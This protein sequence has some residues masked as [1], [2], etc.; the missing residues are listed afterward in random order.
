MPEARV[1]FP[2]SP[3]DD[4]PGAERTMHPDDR[5]DCF[6]TL[7]VIMGLCVRAGFDFSRD[8]CRDGTAWAMAA[9]GIPLK[10]FYLEIARP[11]IM[12]FA[13]IFAGV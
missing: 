1:W 11:P 2:F 4:W 10:S 7:K 6:L 3:R 9:T 12:R 13:G 8:N 5:V